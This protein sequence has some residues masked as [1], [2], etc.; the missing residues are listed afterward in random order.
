M[1]GILATLGS[2][3]VNLGDLGGHFGDLG[4]AVCVTLESGVV[5]L[6]DLG[7][8][9]GDLGGTLMTLGGNSCDLGVKCGQ[10]G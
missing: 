4:W 10:T 9:L 5:K 2:G 8:H 6:V 7:G 1:G 3:V